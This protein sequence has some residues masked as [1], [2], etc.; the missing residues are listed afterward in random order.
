MKRNVKG[1]FGLLIFLAV[2]CFSATAQTAAEKKAFYGALS[3]GNVTVLDKQIAVAKG[4]KGKEVAA[5]EGALLMRKSHL[6]K[7]PAQKMS[8]FKQGLKLL[9]SS[10]GRDPGNAEYRFLRLMIQE[11][12]PK[13]VGYNK[14]IVED[15]HA[16]KN[17]YK[18]L[19]VETQQAVLAY[20]K[21]SKMLAGLK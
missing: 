4:L 19:P 5:F 9:E 14:S 8:M 12:A 13:V 1:W 17:N 15:A 3:S 7:V 20:S 6:L 11:N 16:I 18:S 2:A 10:I 21:S